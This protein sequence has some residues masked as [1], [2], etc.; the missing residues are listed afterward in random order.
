MDILKHGRH[1]EIIEPEFLR[2]A[3]Q[4]EMQA[5]QEIYQ[6]NQHRIAE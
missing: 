2:Q 1:V 3:V 6:K 4:D 5:M